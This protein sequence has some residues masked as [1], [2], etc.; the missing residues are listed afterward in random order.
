MPATTKNL[1]GLDRLEAGATYT[2]TWK[3]TNTSD[4]AYNLSGETFSAKFRNS[5]DGTDVFAAAIAFSTDGTNGIIVFTIANT[6]TAAWQQL[7]VAKQRD[8][9]KGVWDLESVKAGVVTRWLEGTW[10]ITEESTY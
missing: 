2:R 5:Y 8:G 9:L 3:L 7:D 10:E 1:T 4:V 6:A